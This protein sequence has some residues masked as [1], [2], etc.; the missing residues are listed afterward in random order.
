MVSFVREKLTRREIAAKNG[1][2]SKLRSELAV[3]N[4]L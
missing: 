1:R 3:R 2:T 4:V